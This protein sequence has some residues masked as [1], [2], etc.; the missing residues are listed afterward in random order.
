[1]SDGLHLLTLWGFA[2]SQPIYDLFGQFPTFLVAHDVDGKDTLVFIFLISIFIPVCL[3]F[4]VWLLGLLGETIHNVLHYSLIFIFILLTI[5]PALMKIPQLSDFLVISLGI[6][7]SGAFVYGYCRSNQFRRMVLFGSP[8]VFIFP[9]YFLFFSPVHKIVFPRDELLQQKIVVKEEVPIV[10]I[11]FDEI[12]TTYL[13]DETGKID[14]VRYPNFAALAADSYWFRSATTVGHSTNVA[15]PAMLTGNYYRHEGESQKLPTFVDYPQNLFTLLDGVYKFNVVETIVKLSPDNI[16][17]NHENQGK[18][19][20][21]LVDT[22]IVYLHIISPETLAG[23]L[24]DITQNRRDFL[25]DVETTKDLNRQEI[26]NDRSVKSTQEPW[27]EGR[28]ELF[29]RFVDSV[30]NTNVPSLNYLEVVFPHYPFEYLPS[31]KRYGRFVLEGIQDAKWGNDEWLVRIGFQRYLLQLGYTDKLVGEL[32]E[33]LKS[34]GLY[35]KAL[36]IITADHGVSFNPGVNRR[37]INNSNF[38]DIMPIP[39]LIKLPYQTDGVISDRRVEIID[40]FRTIAEVIGVNIP[41]EV[42]GN[43]VFDTLYE[44]K[45]ETNIRGTQDWMFN[46][47]EIDSSR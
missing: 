3:V 17:S 1:L 15:I 41:W 23:K 10:F 5:S 8:A 21:L 26:S 33:K 44:A 11:A 25:A 4:F 9:L 45:P 2:V 19:F 35:N 24:P 30:Q 38:G 27:H 20:T 40:I 37:A 7:I 29:S 18:M 47:S 16:P 6:I 28:I 13:F 39:L 34:V 31:G 43:S 42:D 14:A 36:I 22:S 46:N 12:T 32:F